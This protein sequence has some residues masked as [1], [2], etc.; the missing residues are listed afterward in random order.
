MGQ[1]VKS[2]VS[3]DGKDGEW[4]IDIWGSNVVAP[5]CVDW[6]P[7]IVDPW[8]SIWLCIDWMLDLWGPVN[9]HSSMIVVVG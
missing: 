5:V 4:F 6:G 9:R 8:T 3:S 1:L 7:F 2:G